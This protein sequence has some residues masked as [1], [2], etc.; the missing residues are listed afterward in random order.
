[1]EDGAEEIHVPA[2]AGKDEHQTRLIGKDMERDIYMMATDQRVYMILSTN[3][4]LG[5][6]SPFPNFAQSQSH[7]CKA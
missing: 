3:N 7:E 4:C 5:A 1:M 6:S 2:G